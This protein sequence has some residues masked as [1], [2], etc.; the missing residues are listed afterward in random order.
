MLH[1]RHDPGEAREPAGSFEYFD[2]GLLVV[3]DG[4]V[5]AVGE[6]CWSA[7]SQ[8]RRSLTTPAG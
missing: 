6:A 7:S 3:R 8:A 4:R 5:S 2:D 1:F